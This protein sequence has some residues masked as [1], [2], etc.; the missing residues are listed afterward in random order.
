MD[1]VMIVTIAAKSDDCY[2]TSEQEKVHE[3][4]MSKSA[5]SLAMVH[6]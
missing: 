4:C 1:D 6:N 5:Q 3:K 2:G